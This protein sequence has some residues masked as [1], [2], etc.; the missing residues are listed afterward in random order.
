M[1]TM[2]SII[3]FKKKYQLLFGDTLK[4]WSEDVKMIRRNIH[5]KKVKPQFPPF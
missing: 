3:S 1:I 4:D 2:Y 5:H